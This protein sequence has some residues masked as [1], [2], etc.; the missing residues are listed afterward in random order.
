MST[1]ALVR[2]SVQTTRPAPAPQ[3]GTDIFASPDAFE[4]AQRVAKVFQSSALVPDHLKKSPADA[5][6]A[7]GIARRLGEDPLVVMQ[8]I[9]FVSGKPGWSV[10]YKIAR[11]NKAGV[12]SKQI[13][14]DVKGEG[15][16]LV[17]KAYA[18]LS[19]GEEVS[20]EVSMKMAKA[21]GWTK[22]SKY[23][24]MP[25]HMLKW[26]SASMLIDLS[27]PEVMLGLPTVY[28]EPTFEMKSRPDGTMEAAPLASGRKKM[29][30]AEIL[31]GDF[32][33]PADAQSADVQPADHDH[34]TGEV[35]EA[36]LEADEA[37]M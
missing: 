31:E 11:A 1:T 35:I 9:Y 6:I 33:R 4:H 2:D 12:F 10:K 23:S 16:A 22:N 18:T 32:E 5:L 17:V 26:R 15:E 36:E 21:E 37:G 24:T 3:S 30:A 7:Y 25:V 27:A 28:E 29:R 34:A 14:W 8:N 20:A 13:K 19:D